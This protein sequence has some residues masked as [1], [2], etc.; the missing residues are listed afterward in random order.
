[1]MNYLDELENFQKT[2]KEEYQ[3][4]KSIRERKFANNRKKEKIAK[5]NFFRAG[6]VALGIG[7]GVGAASLNYFNS[8]KEE[9]NNKKIVSE[10]TS[11][12]LDSL[13]DIVKSATHRTSDNTGVWLD[14]GEI[15]SY[16]NKQEDKDIAIYTLLNSYG[17]SSDPKYNGITNESL[18]YVTDTNGNN[19][20]GLDD[21][22]SKKG[23][24]DINDYKKQMESKILAEHEL[25]ELIQELRD[26]E[27]E[28]EISSIK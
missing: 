28:K 26:S 25:G 2:E 5:K 21:Y 11:E 6:L 24:N 7:V 22:L 15:G 17:S 27:T 8:K 12:E 14:Y 13:R 18:R 9:Y 1:M 3:R 10:E 23:V 16:I 20:T 4:E 19:Y